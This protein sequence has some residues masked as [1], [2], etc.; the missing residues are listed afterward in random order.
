M[1]NRPFSFVFA[2]DLV[3]ESFSKISDHIPNKMHFFGVFSGHWRAQIFQS[4]LAIL[5]LRLNFFHYLRQ[6]CP[7]MVEHHSRQLRSQRSGSQQILRHRRIHR[8]LTKKLSFRFQSFVHTTLAI[9]IYFW[10]IHYS[11]VSKL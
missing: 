8:M 6:K 5:N 1:F 9:N 11:N 2:T 10:A 7:N 3:F 4:L